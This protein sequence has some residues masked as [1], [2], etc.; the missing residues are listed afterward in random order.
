MTG[1]ILI[2]STGLA[3]P[4]GDFYVYRDDWGDAGS[5][6]KIGVCTE[7]VLN[8]ESVVIS[9][10]RYEQDRVNNPVVVGVIDNTLFTATQSIAISDG[11]RV[12]IRNS[13][14]GGLSGVARTSGSIPSAG[15]FPSG[16]ATGSGAASI[17]V[18]ATS[19]TDGSGA[20]S[21]CNSADAGWVRLLVRSVCDGIVISTSTG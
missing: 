5:I 19:L 12:A 15:R 1:T 20:I 18:L 17:G 9:G 10:T 4:Y 7:D 2:N 6:L 13:S 16:I 14:D 3:F 21:F 11:L 8:L